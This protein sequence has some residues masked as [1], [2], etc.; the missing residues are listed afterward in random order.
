MRACSSEMLQRIQSDFP[1]LDL[2]GE[3][4]SIDT[5]HEHVEILLDL[6]WQAKCVVAS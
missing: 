2:A 5:L 3:L 4:F 1:A 6:F